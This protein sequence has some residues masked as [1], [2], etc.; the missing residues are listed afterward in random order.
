V[1]TSFERTP[2]QRFLASSA[3][4]LSSSGNAPCWRCQP[5]WR[6]RRIPG[7]VGGGRRQ[8]GQ[9]CGIWGSAAARRRNNRKSVRRSEVRRERWVPPSHRE[10]SSSGAPVAATRSFHCLLQRTHHLQIRSIHPY[11]ALFGE[12][13][14][15]QSP[16]QQNRLPRSHP[17]ASLKFQT[18]KAPVALERW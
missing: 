11:E 5:P 6:P 17:D 13:A 2:R 7:P 10:G 18:S 14:R 12:E 3:T 8:R 9:W 15:S 4:P 16:K 1:A